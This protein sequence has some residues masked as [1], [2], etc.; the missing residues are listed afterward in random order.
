[1]GLSHKKH[2]LFLLSQKQLGKPRAFSLNPPQD[3]VILEVR[4]VKIPF[5]EEKP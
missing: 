1:M 4:K 2:K 3:C 5:H